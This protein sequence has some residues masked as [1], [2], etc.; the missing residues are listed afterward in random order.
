ML[1]KLFISGLL[2]WLPLIAT[3]WVIQFVVGLLDKLLKILPSQFQPDQLF[4]MHI[5]GFGLLLS[6]IIVFV[7]GLLVTNILGDKLIEWWDAGMKRVPLVGAI[8]ST[9]KQVLQTLVSSD[10]QSF[11]KVLLV[12]YPRQGCWSIAFQ[13]G[14][15]SDAVKNVTQADML[16]VFV[17]TTPN[18]TSGF[19]LMIPKEQTREIDMPVEQAFKIIVSLGTLKS[20]I[21]PMQPKS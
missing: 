10:G 11:R 4:G 17:P 8:Y 2:I 16:S 14:E 12:E 3:I 6:V 5:P 20:D 21:L 7:T 19:L 15:A 18:P 9:I 13:T 1:K